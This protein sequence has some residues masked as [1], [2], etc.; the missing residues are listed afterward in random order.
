MVTQ[1]QILKSFAPGK[2]PSDTQGGTRLPPWAVG[3]TTDT[4]GSAGMSRRNH[5]RHS[6]A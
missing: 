3:N 2:W 5:S 4:F 6:T 1:M